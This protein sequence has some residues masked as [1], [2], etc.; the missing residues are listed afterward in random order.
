MAGEVGIYTIVQ[1]QTLRIFINFGAI[2]SPHLQA[3]KCWRSG[4]DYPFTCELNKK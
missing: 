3:E 2:D 1:K 4:Y